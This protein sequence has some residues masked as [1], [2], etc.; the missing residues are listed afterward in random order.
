MKRLICLC[1]CTFIWRIK[2][3]YYYYLPDSSHDQICD[4]KIVDTYYLDNCQTME[5]QTID[6][7]QVNQFIMRLKRGKAP[8]SDGIYHEHLIFGNSQ[9]LCASLASLYTGIL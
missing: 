7:E 8:G 6:A 4:K 2:Y 5:I 3:Y 9:V 1:F